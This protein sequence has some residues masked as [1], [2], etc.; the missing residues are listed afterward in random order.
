MVI[1]TT[2]R[3]SSRVSTITVSEESSS[4][5]GTA[6]S[7]AGSKRLS[8]PARWL[9]HRAHADLHVTVDRRL[10]VAEAHAIVDRVQHALSDY[11]PA[12]GGATIHVCPCSHPEPV[13]TEAAGAA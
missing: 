1:D 8:A 9:G 5:V 13:A 3:P 11:V 2:L 7:A 6:G 12:F 4:P 10:S